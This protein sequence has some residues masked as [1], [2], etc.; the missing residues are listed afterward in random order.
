MEYKGYH[1][2]IRYSDEDK[3][4]I[5]EVIGVTDTL[6]FHGIQCQDSF[7]ASSCCSNLCKKE[8]SVT[9]RICYGSDSR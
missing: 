9:K 5:G 4:F 1:A 2:D 8:K 6:G 7:E 3:L